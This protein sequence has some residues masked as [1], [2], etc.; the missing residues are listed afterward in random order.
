M[1]LLSYRALFPVDIMAA[2]FLLLSL[3]WGD[4]QVSKG[5][6]TLANDIS[7]QY[8]QPQNERSYY[9]QKERTW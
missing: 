6:F 2:Q 1:M 5:L 4:K 8:Q 3:S 7:P 9:S